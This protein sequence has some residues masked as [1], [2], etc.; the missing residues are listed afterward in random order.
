MLLALQRG[1]NALGDPFHREASRQA[2]DE[3]QVGNRVHVAQRED[4]LIFL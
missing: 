3:Y 4:R 2:I 1:A